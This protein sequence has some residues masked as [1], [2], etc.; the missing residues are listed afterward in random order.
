MAN[1]I[2]YSSVSKP[3]IITAIIL[4]FIGTAIGSIWMMSILGTNLPQWLHG[5]FEL[6][7]M[8]QMDGFLTLLI[9]GIGYM[10]VPR[11]RNIQL[12]SVKLAYVSFLLIL[13]SLIFQFIQAVGDEKNL[14]MCLVIS[15]LSGLII[16]VVIVFWTM[17]VRPKLL[18]ISDYFIALSLVTLI[19]INVIDLSG[20]RYTNSLTHVQ[21]WL[22]F[23]ILMIFGIE[24]KTLPAFLGFIRPRKASATASLVSISICMILG[25]VSVIFA[26]MS[27]LLSVIFNV[28]LFASVLLF[29][30]AVYAFGGFDNRE[31]LRLVKGERKARYNF[32]GNHIKIAFLFLFLG[33]IMAILF[34]LVGQYFVFYDLAIHSIAIGFIGL[35]IAL[36]LPL[37]LP[38]VVGKIINFTSFNNIPLF[39]V[40]VSLIIRVAGDFILAQPFSSSSLGYIWSSSHRILTYFFGL[41]GWFIVAAMLAFV[42]MIHKSMKEVD[43]LEEGAAA[44]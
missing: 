6:H 37:M 13:G 39:L 1:T 11:F 21:L 15:R 40:I 17:R 14:S 9:M 7:K 42:I 22:L 20:Y 38:P 36:Y 12:G 28:I 8:L 34:N 32:I 16:F 44:K 25:F 43:H 35:T 27:L 5:T 10:I 19:T 23:P 3:F 26:N 30:T 29:A 24:Y 18:G 41:S 33:V 31:I 4:L 2:N